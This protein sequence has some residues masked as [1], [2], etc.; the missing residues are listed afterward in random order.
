MLDIE[1][2]N[3]LERKIDFKQRNGA[4][5]SKEESELLAMMGEIFEMMEGVLENAEDVPSETDL[6]IQKELT[7]DGP[8]P[9]IPIAAC[10]HIFPYVKKY[11]Q[12][13]IRNFMALSEKP[14]NALVEQLRESYE[15]FESVFFLFFDA[16]KKF[17]GD[18]C[19][20]RYEEFPVESFDDDLK[21]GLSPY[22]IVQDALEKLN[23]VLEYFE[24]A[25][26]EPSKEKCQTLSTVMFIINHD[27]AFS[28]MLATR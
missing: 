9:D 28:G 7:M 18:A 17:C 26:A 23:L 5:T 8:I 25:L 3:E 2:Y 21:D 27:I 4:D 1:R 22:E 14:E 20:Y 16:V 6:L 12:N 24:F 15:Y 10:R 11:S 13:L 19:E